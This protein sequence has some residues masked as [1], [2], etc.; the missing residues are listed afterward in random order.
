MLRTKIAKICD[1]FSNF[2]SKIKIVKKKINRQ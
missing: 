1:Y 2:A